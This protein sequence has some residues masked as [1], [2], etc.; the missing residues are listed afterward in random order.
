M[1][2]GKIAGLYLTDSRCQAPAPIPAPIPEAAATS[3]H[4]QPIPNP[5]N[6]GGQHN[7]HSQ[8]D[9]HTSPQ[10]NCGEGTVLRNNI[11]IIENNSDA[12]N[13]DGSNDIESIVLYY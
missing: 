2:C 5:M 11:C 8:N 1:E 7:N 9:L 6:D 13:T 4:N 12:T 10:V 3:V